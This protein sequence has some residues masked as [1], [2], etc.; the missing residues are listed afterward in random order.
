MMVRIPTTVL[1]LALVGAGCSRTQDEEP[2][3]A[4]P[5]L[6][7]PGE[8]QLIAEPLLD[9]YAREGP[10]AVRISIRNGSDSAF[11]FRPILDFGAFLDAEIV[12]KR[13]EVLP[14][15]MEL[16]PP[17]AGEVRLASGETYSDTVD[18]RCSM[19]VIELG[20]CSSM[21]DLTEPGTYEVRMRF[22]APCDPPNCRRAH[23]R[24]EADPFR[25]SIRR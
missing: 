13:G 3:S 19:L 15:T 1:L 8:V 14:K 2:Q 16:D 25:V 10:I 20:E 4:L 23:E 22:A 9:A 17:N 21:Y 5:E 11:V 12:D 18:I 7:A 6:S 24:L